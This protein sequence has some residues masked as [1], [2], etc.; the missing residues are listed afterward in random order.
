MQTMSPN[1]AHTS[2]W[3]KT[4]LCL[5]CLCQ[6]IPASMAGA[7]LSN[8][9]RPAQVM[10]LVF[11][12]HSTGQAWLSD[13]YGRLGLAL[14]NN[15]YF[16]SD[17]N[18]GWGPDSIGD[19]TDIGHWWKWFR[20]PN[21][22]QYMAALHAESRQNCEYSRLETAP[23]GPNQIVMFKSCFP[24][25]LLQGSP[26]DPVPPI[27]E[28]PLRGQD[29][30]SETFTVAN[31]KGIYID[32]LEYL[33]TMPDKLFVV[34][35]AP[36]MSDTGT[37]NNARAF[38]QWIYEDWLKN[39]PLNNVF[40]WDYYNVLTS[41]AG[42]PHANDLDR[43]T[44]NHH[45]WWNG[46]VQHK[47]DGG[48]NISAYPSSPGD[49]HPSGEGDL[50][51]TAEYVPLLNAAVRAW[52]SPQVQAPQLSS[53]RVAG[54]RIELTI[55]N[56]TPGVN[57]TVQRCADLMVG[58]WTDAGALIGQSGPANWSESVNEQWGQMFYRV[59]GP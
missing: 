56:L 43:E 29:A 44:G 10:R 58:T 20:S 30:F 57:Y 21:S 27:A 17:T 9:N 7:A 8:T 26:S 3:F 28:N 41:N 4:A 11:I 18:Y 19:T 35:T 54:Q 47:T 55:D 2:D 59:K 53:V 12:H 22:P 23:D 1:K 45:R 49:D 15:N 42:N 40:V 6:A 34:I 16:V 37:A 33:R 32:L 5:A 46:A 25:S 50:K 31:A 38:N 51:A 13:G 36:P 24:N 52:L 39:Y 48:G 14:R